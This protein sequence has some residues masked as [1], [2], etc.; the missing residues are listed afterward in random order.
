[1]SARHLPK[2][3]GT[4]YTMNDN[5]AEILKQFVSDS[6]INPYGDG[7]INDT[8]LTSSENFILQKINTG[9]FNDPDKLMENIVNVTGFLKKKISEKGG[10]PK[11]E[12]LTVIKTKDGKNYYRTENGNSYRLYIYI[13]NSYSVSVAE[14]PF[15]LYNAGK[16]FGRFQSMLNDYPAST[17]YEVIP[18]FHNTRMRFNDF[19]KAVEN[20]TAKRASLCKDEIDFVL[21][22]KDCIDIITD[23]IKNGDIPLRVTHNDTKINNVLFDKSNND[24][25]CVI[26]LDT[27]MPGS[28]LF[29]FG[30]ALR[31]GAAT[32]AED[33]KDLS[34]VWFDLYA[35]KN[36]AKGY[37]EETAPILTKREIELLPMSA[38]I[39][40][41]E[42]G[43]RFLT[44]Y[45]NGDTYFKV[46]RE[47]H[48]LDRARTQF[49]LVKDI[50]N[51]YEEMQNIIKNIVKQVKL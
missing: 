44:D 35:F 50:E 46:H 3:K 5:L 25:L 38:K 14:N 7:H 51:K 32:A 49:K 26:D 18:N 20:D 24:G 36:F 22:G 39:L 30:D 8:Y 47:G 37:L 21:S 1:M 12:T 15:Q 33:E 23:G 10:D 2:W 45:L 42:C 43:M 19:L 31:S 41:Y 17:L 6:I 48:N 40:T 9:I 28:M 4:G 11:R 34:K 13:D 29:D 27:V 16:A